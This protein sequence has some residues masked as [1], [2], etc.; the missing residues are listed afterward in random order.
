MSKFSKKNFCSFKNHS[1]VQK[2]FSS[3]FLVYI[4][5]SMYIYLLVCIKRSGCPLISYPTSPFQYT[6]NF[7]LLSEIFRNITTI[8]WIPSLNVCVD[9]HYT[10]IHIYVQ[11]PKTGKQN[12]PAG[13]ISE[14]RSDVERQQFHFKNLIEKK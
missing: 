5:L 1:L 12:R 7:W 13:G 14:H 11:K 9:V 3:F 8:I 10:Y 4:Y 6:F 2:F